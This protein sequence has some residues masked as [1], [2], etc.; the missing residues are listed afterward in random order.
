MINAALF[1]VRPKDQRPKVV[2]RNQP[3]PEQPQ[4]GRWLVVREVL[5]AFRLGVP[6][7]IERAKFTRRGRALRDTNYFRRRDPW[8]AVRVPTETA[9][10]TS[11]CHDWGDEL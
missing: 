4:W 8:F 6:L 1:C 10:P 7:C 9:G 11:E 5:E 3:F 2:L